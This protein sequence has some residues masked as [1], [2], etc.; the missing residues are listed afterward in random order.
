MG[1]EKQKRTTQ[2]LSMDELQ[3]RPCEVDGFPAW[4]HRW[5]E[6]DRVLLQVDGMF[7]AESEAAMVRRFHAQHVI[8]PGCHSEVVRETFALVEYP[9]G[10]VATV[11]PELVRFVNE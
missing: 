10:V 8:S 6:Q 9:D 11:K 7:S 2:L 3:R 1:V 4:F 5:V